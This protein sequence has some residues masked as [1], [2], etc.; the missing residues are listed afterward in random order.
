MYHS[1]IKCQN[2]VKQN[3]ACY[4]KGNTTQNK[5]WKHTKR[6]VY[7]SLIQQCLK[8]NKTMGDKRIQI[9]NCLDKFV[10]KT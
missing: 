6:C 5:K 9:D 4:M 8:H 3:D 1:S 7:N 10:R 2:K